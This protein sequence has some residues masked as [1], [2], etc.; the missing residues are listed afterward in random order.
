MLKKL[1]V[2]LLLL[3]NSSLL[4]LSSF[5]G[6]V[7]FVASAQSPVANGEQFYLTYNINAQGTDFR[8]PAI[9]DFSVISG[10]S[11]SSSTNVQWINGQMTQ[12]ITISYTYI[13][14]AVKEGTFTIPPASINI[15]GKTYQSNSLSIT[16]VKG[17]ANPQPNRQQRQ[18]QGQQNNTSTGEINKDDIFV[19]TIVSKTSA[20]KGEALLITQKIYTRVSISGFEDV[21]MPSYKD[22]WTEEIKMPAQVNL[23]RETYNGVVYNVAELKKTIVIPQKAGRIEIE[24]AEITCIAQVQAKRQSRSIWDDFFGGGYQNVRYKVIG[25]PVSIDVKSLPTQ[26]QPANFEG[27]VGNFTLKSEIDKN[28]V[29]TN[30]AVNLQITITGNGNLKLFDKL[31]AE[32]PSDFETY[33]P[34]VTSNLNTS[35][36]GI[37]GSRKFEYLLIPRNPGKFTIKPI[38]FSYFDIASKTYKT[39]STPEYTIIVTKGT[40]ASSNVTY[41]SVNQEDVKFIGSDIRYIK[42][43]PYILVPVGTFFF[44]SSLFYILLF[45]P[46]LLFILFVIFWGKTLKQRSNIALMRNKKATKVARKR[47]KE[48]EKQLKLMN[49]DLFYEEISK[50]IWGYISDKFSIPVAD[51]SVITVRDMLLSKGIKED[52]INKITEILNNCEFARFAPGDSTAAM[53]NIYNEAADLISTVE[54]ELK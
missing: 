7:Q 3:F 20:Y 25:K 30:E 14:Q 4:T 21:K 22:F 8:A 10:P 39:L 24:P 16:V 36:G 27:A 51:L 6:N 23:H 42:N 17:S 29:K 5:A 48:A 49:K 50:S 44:G 45:S 52:I 32:F 12:S 40:G 11:Q 18:G 19:R 33:D 31:N 41:S 43:A 53:N 54:N 34:K 26:N 1:N 9:R 38:S 28:D 35:E 46:L 37:S 15:G 13:L 2:F 47:L